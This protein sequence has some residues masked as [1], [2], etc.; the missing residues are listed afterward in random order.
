MD[1]LCFRCGPSE[2]QWRAEKVDDVMDWVAVRRRTK[3]RT[4]QQSRRK[5][6]VFVKVDGSRAI[7]MD[8]ALSDKVS[9][10]VTQIPNGGCGSESDVCGTSGG[11]GPGRGEGAE[12]L[13]SQRWQ[14]S[15]GHEKDARRRKT[16]DPVQVSRVKDAEGPKSGKGSSDSGV[17]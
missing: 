11:R 9:D 3:S 1:F 16:S 4:Q 8:V 2:G 15:S 7:T 13:Q 17:R 10:V 6:K 14:H 12:M 5:V